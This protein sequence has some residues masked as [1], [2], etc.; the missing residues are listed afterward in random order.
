MLAHRMETRRLQ[1]CELVEGGNIEKWKRMTKTSIFASELNALVRCPSHHSCKDYHLSEILN[2]KRNYDGRCDLVRHLNAELQQW[3]TELQGGRV[4]DNIFLASE[5]IFFRFSFP[6]LSN[7]LTR[8]LFVN[9]PHNLWTNTGVLHSLPD[10][11]VRIADDKVVRL[12]LQYHIDEHLWHPVADDT[13]FWNSDIITDGGTKSWRWS[14][15]IAE[16]EGGII[17]PKGMIEF[18]TLIAHQYL[19]YTLQNC[20]YRYSGHMLFG[21]GDIGQICLYLTTSDIRNFEPHAQS[22]SSRRMPAFTGSSSVLH[23]LKKSLKRIIKVIEDPKYGIQPPQCWYVQQ[24]DNL[25]GDAKSVIRN[26]MECLK[27]TY[28]IQNVRVLR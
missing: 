6:L 1:L 22:A 18:D 4:K 14:E 17:T 8:E 27:T 12:V 21:S 19:K 15:F 20:L 2:H 24:V 16:N 3:T 25:S 5:L 9:N 23:Q 11:S 10:G 13:Q 26:T 7:A 28:K